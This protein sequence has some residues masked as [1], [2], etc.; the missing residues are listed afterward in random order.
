MPSYPY[1][2]QSQRG[3]VAVYYRSNP[4]NYRIKWC[5]GTILHEEVRVKEEDALARAQ[6]I[7]DAI[8]AA[9][10]TSQ[11]DTADLGTFRA[12]EAM[13]PAGTSLLDAVR[14]FIDNR[15]LV[16]QRDAGT[17]EAA[18]LYIASLYSR[19]LSQDY[20]KSVTHHLVHFARL[21]GDQTVRSITVAQIDSF[22]L[23]FE[24]PRYRDNARGSLKSLFTWAQKQ[25]F[26]PHGPTAAHRSDRPRV[27]KKDPVIFAV[28][29]FETLMHRAEQAVPEAIPY[30]AIG[31]FAGCRA[32][33]ASRLRPEDIDLEQGIISLSS[34]ITKTGRRRIA[35]ITPNLK[36]WL[37]RYPLQEGASFP[38]ARL[39]DLCRET[40]IQW[41][42]NGPRKSFVSYMLATGN[43]TFDLAAQCGHSA[44]VAATCYAALATPAQG[45][46]WFNINP[47]EKEITL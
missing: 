18:R 47:I 14:F 27:P 24:N 45:E 11:K 19:G 34:S 17:D 31:A 13:L 15:A 32:S 10:P 23:T 22:L 1:I 20:L 41:V 29:D 33:E 30:L 40:R 26:L 42:A 4:G 25:E 39:R 2:L 8:E 43:K 36:A 38:H 44:A 46:A 28:G 6:E 37:T 35:K 16:T 21:V 5:Q 9:S 7:F 12:V 3:K